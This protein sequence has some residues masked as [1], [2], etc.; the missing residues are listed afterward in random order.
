MQ[1]AI[2]RI[3]VGINIEWVWVGP[4]EST[5]REEI[6]DLDDEDSSGEE[7]FGD[8]VIDDQVNNVTTPPKMES[9]DIM[10]RN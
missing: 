7:G 4:R 2:K 5:P 1:R 8:A 9:S 10:V 3:F 6:I